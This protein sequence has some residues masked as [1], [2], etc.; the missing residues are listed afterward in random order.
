MN[1]KNQNTAPMK[2]KDK[3]KIK[4]NKIKSYLKKMR[5]SQVQLA[6]DCGTNPAHI[7]RIVNGKSEH[8]SLAMAIKLAHVM[9]V[10]VEKLFIL[11]K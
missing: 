5:L 10:P 3:K 9:K 6:Y 1:I 11:E 4:S 8:I 7:S 2:K